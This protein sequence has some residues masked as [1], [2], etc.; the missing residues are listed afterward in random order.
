M[1]RAGAEVG[2]A[3][4]EELLVGVE[5]GT[6]VVAPGEG[7][8]GEDEV[9]VADQ[10]DAHGGQYQVWQLGQVR[11]GHDGKAQGDVTDHGDAVSAVEVEDRHGR[12]AERHDEQGP[13]DTAEEVG[14]G[15]EDAECHNGEQ[16]CGRMDPR[17]VPYKGPQL[18]EEGRARRS[19]TGQFGKLVHDHD[20]RHARQIADEYRSG[21]QIR[22][23]AE[24]RRPCQH[25][26]QADRDR[27]GGRQC[28]VTG[29]ISCG[30]RPDHRRRHQ[31]GRGL[32][33]DREQARGA[34]DGVQGE[35]GQDGP[36]PGDRRQAGHA[37]VRHHLGYEIRG[38]RHSGQYVALQ[39]GAPIAEQ[40]TEPGQ[41]T[42]PPRSTADRTLGHD[43]P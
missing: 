6:L 18:G 1:Q 8:G 32:R 2:R 10:Q 14:H 15:E 16:H 34:E 26:Q 13:G 7:S 27:E 21:Q 19:G 12:G 17:Q 35:R 4:R 11:H 5:P 29:R 42:A 9:G 43:P 36:Q 24:P 3:Q 22:D 31:R 40:R 39:P 38:H 23:E 25:A 28:R 20:Q 37:R 30:E 41:Q 33:S